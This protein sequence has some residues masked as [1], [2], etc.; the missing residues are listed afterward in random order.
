LLNTFHQPFS[1]EF[2]LCLQFSS[3]T[4]SPPANSPTSSFISTHATPLYLFALLSFPLSCNAIIVL[5]S[6]ETD[7]TLCR[8]TW[9]PETS[10]HFFRDIQA[11]EAQLR[12]DIVAAV[13]SNG[14][15]LLVLAQTDHWMHD[16]LPDS[17]P[18]WQHA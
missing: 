18:V 5:K 14:K 7:L 2:L 15:S 6:C 11:C 4:S 12:D 8:R 1:A 13:A 16:N 10:T 3:S 9:L 17:Q